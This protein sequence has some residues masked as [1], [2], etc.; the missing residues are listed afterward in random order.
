MIDPKELMLARRFAYQ[1]IGRLTDPTNVLDARD[2]IIAVR[3]VLV[4]LEP[5]EGKRP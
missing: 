1:V 4:C 2:A 3:L 5:Y